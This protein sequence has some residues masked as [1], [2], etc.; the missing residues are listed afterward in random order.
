MAAR[1][2][3]NQPILLVVRYHRLTAQIDSSCR[4]VDARSPDQGGTR[5]VYNI[6]S[7]APRPR[8]DFIEILAIRNLAGTVG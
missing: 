6:K 4:A 5:A 3:G 8:H 1:L 2:E 7:V